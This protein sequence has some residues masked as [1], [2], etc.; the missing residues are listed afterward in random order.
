MIKVTIGDMQREFDSRS[1]IEEAW[2]NQQPA[3]NGP[4]SVRARARGGGF[5]ERDVRLRGVRR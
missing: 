3:R 1:D 4:G 2:I 5:D